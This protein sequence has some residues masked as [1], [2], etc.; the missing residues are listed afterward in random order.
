MKK[1]LPITSIILFFSVLSCLAESENLLQ[2]ASFEGLA[3]GTGIGEPWRTRARGEQTTIEVAR[4][5]DD[6][7]GNW[8]LVKDY[9]GQE[10]VYLYTDV[11]QVTKGT[12]SFRLYFPSSS[13]TVG[14]YLRNSSLDKTQNNIIE[15][16]CLEDSGNIYV[17]SNGDRQKLPVIASGAEYLSFD[18][19]FDA[20][21]AGEKIDVYVNDA[22][23]RHLIHSML[24]PDG[25]PIDTVMITTDTQT[26][27]SEFYVGDLKLLRG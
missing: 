14:I 6:A 12:L 22:T 8:V 19:E 3:A 4:P 2:S 25:H 5:K 11:P 18:I 26:A 24:S 21:D 23:G 1:I 17:G 27:G 16:K 20:T 7:S 10:K 9:D 13:A 15:F